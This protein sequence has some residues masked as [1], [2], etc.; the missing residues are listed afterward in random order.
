MHAVSGKTD[1]LGSHCYQQG[2]WIHSEG[3]SKDLGIK[4]KTCAAHSARRN[5][6]TSDS[7]ERI[8]FKPRQLKHALANESVLVCMAMHGA[9]WSSG[10]PGEKATGPARVVLCS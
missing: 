3:F 6:Y 5:S 4:G 2:T 1:K 9:L 10:A 8:C 7:L